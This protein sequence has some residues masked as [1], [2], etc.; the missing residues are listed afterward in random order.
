M[1]PIAGIAKRLEESLRPK[2]S[3]T[4]SLTALPSE[5]ELCEGSGWVTIEG[6]AKKCSCQCERAIRGA[7][8]PLFH[9]ATLAQFPPAMQQRVRKWLESPGD[10]LLLTGQAGCG[11]TFLA[12][13]IVREEIEAGRT[14]SFRVM[15]KIYADLRETFRVNAP[16][17][18]VLGPCV[19]SKMIVLDDLGAGALSDFE[20]R[21]A[22][23]IIDARLNALRPTIVTT[24]LGLEEIGKK[25]DDRLASRLSSYEGLCIEG[26][27]RRG[28]RV[29]R[30]G[31][32]GR[33]AA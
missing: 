4:R 24:N 19:D 32:S 22:L 20:R 14:C 11:K 27:D 7:L 6:R 30:P 5:C 18:Q 31:P 16:E 17:S 25:I 26:A 13:A 23:D 1:E 2:V 28:I 10:G 21:A 8:P 29:V 12:A 33:S 3:S 15:R 9:E